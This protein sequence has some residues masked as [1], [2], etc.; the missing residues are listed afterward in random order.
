MLNTAEEEACGLEV[1][2][3]LQEAPWNLNAYQSNLSLIWSNIMT[4][5]AQ[6]ST[7]N[8]VTSPSQQTVEEEPQPVAEE[9]VNEETR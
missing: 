9:E 2:V 6:R 8:P 5:A 1:E 4:P 3:N 7:F